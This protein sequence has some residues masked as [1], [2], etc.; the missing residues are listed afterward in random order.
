MSDFNAPSCIVMTRSVDAAASRLWVT[1]TTA[2]WVAAVVRHVVEQFH[3]RRPGGR[4][5]VSGWLI[6]QDEWRIHHQR[7]RHG[8][9][10]HLAT[11]Q[12]AG[13]V[14]D[15]IAESD[16]LEQPDGIGPYVSQLLSVKQDW[17]LP[18]S[19]TPTGSATG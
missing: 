6:S 3:D 5:Q 4:V 10:L 18:R 1:I 8:N 15:A 9:A 14:I 7:P 19:P 11:G 2:R 13:A 17:G 12:L 16:K